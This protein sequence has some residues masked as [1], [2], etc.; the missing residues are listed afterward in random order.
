MHVHV[1]GSAAGGGFPQ[2]NCNCPN[3]AGVRD[4][5]LNARVRT[6]SSV[7]FSANGRDWLLCNTSPDLLR[8]LQQFPQAQPARSI[9]DTAIAAILLIDAQIDHTTGLY[10]LREHD[11]PLPVWCTD[12]AREDLQRGNPILPLLDHYCGTDLHKIPVDG[13]RFEIPEVGG[14]QITALS[15]LSNA[16]PYS[17]HR[18]KPVRGDNIGLLIESAD[19]GRRLFY[20]PGLGR[21]EP[22]VWQAMQASDTVMVDGTCWRDD[23]MLELG[24]SR[25]RARDMGH[26]PQSGAGGMLEWLN[27]LPASTRKILIHINN[28]NPI[29][30]EDSA[31]HA[32]LRSAGIELAHDG[33]EFSL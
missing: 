31:E 8:Q 11:R 29:L 15:L 2:W 9:R 23:E 3:C 24:I 10:M 20:A 18:D 22:H 14:L 26:L 5:T 28:T 21:M 25:K 6:Q 27:K 12:P 17:P 4:G 33:M 16:P 7:A 13:G 19:S 32:Q 1:L 30:N